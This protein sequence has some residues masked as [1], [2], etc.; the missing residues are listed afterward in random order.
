MSYCRYCDCWKDSDGCGCS[1]FTPRV[2][3]DGTYN[4]PRSTEAPD[5]PR[6]RIVPKKENMKKIQVTKSVTLFESDLKELL[7]RKGPISVEFV[8]TTHGG[9][10]REAWSTPGYV[11]ITWVEE[12]DVNLLKERIK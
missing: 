1:P 3:E 10:M 9:D 4:P 6:Q 7:G 11:K 5:L 2:R 8:A 12:E